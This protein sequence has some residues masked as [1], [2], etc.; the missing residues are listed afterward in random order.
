MCKP[1]LTRLSPGETKVPKEL[2]IRVR[3]SCCEASSGCVCNDDP[4]THTG[5]L[6]VD[7]SSV[8]P[9]SLLRGSTLYSLKACDSL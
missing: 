3:F 8:I 5:Q 6:F 2:S 4:T 1:S 9:R 7:R